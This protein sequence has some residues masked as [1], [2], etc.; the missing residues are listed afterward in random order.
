MQNWTQTILSQYAASPT[1]NALIGSLNVAIDPV[2]DIA[3]IYSNL[4]NLQTASGQGLNNWGQIVGVQR[5]LRA[6][7]APTYFGFGE[8]YSL[9]TSAT[10][11]Q[12]FGLATMYAGPAATQTYYLDDADY[13]TLIMVKAAAN[14][15]SLTAPT[16]NTLLT[17]ALGI[18]KSP[19]GSILGVGV[20]PFTLA[21][22]SSRAY[23][24]D[25]G[26][27]SQRYVLEFLPTVQQMAILL[28]SGVIPRSAGVQASVLVYPPFDTFGFSEMSGTPFG[29]GT[30][31]PTSGLINAT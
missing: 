14:I 29:F 10:G 23:V 1:I 18:S 6:P 19:A 27:M 26:A 20:L 12:P 24:Q 8:A 22:T 2:A 31:F 7:T 21:S 28:Q 15:G 25:T 4:W 5:S 30:L 11:V 16:M 3:N 9:T 13:R 17:Q